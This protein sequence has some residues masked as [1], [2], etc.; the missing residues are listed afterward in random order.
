MDCAD[1]S[2]KVT[3]RKKKRRVETVKMIRNGELTANELTNEPTNFIKGQHN[4]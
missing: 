2:N 4:P 1:T 3:N